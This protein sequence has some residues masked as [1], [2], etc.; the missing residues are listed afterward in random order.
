MDEWK[1][2]PPSFVAK[3]RRLTKLAKFYLIFMLIEIFLFIG[4]AIFVKYFNPDVLIVVLGFLIIIVVGVA[5]NSAIRLFYSVEF[6]G[7]VSRFLHKKSKF[8]STPNSSNRFCTKC[9]RNIPLDAYICP[10]CGNDF[11]KFL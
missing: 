5:V 7:E 3:K 6:F 8:E 11:K 9:G 4:W 1:K 10:Y 2:P